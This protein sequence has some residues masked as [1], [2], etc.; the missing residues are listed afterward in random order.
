MQ[1]R[2]VSIAAVLLLGLLVTSVP[3][4][5]TAFVPDLVPVTMPPATRQDQFQLPE[6]VAQ[7]LSSALENPPITKDFLIN[8]YNDGLIQAWIAKTALRVP[9]VTNKTSTAPV[10]LTAFYVEFN[11]NGIFF[12]ASG[13]DFQVELLR[14]LNML[15]CEN[16]TDQIDYCKAIRAAIR[17]TPQTTFYSNMVTA[18]K[19]AKPK[20]ASR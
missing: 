16:S 19:G 5:A 7:A 17:A 12:G 4:L 15:T 3:N 11:E 10:D 6:N 1:M 20:L 14:E 8:I 2:R 18:L 9:L 13:V